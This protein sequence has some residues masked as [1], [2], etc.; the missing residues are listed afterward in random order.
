MKKFPFISVLLLLTINVLFLFLPLT[1][2]FGYE[3]SLFNS[4]LVV[5][6]SG[7]LTIN[8]I[9]HFRKQGRGKTLAELAKW[10]LIFFVIP[11]LISLVNSLFTGFCSFVQGLSFYFIFVFPALIIGSAIGAA[12]IY[13]WTRYKFIIFALLMLLTAFITVYEIYFNPQSYFYNPLFGYFPGTI[14]DEGLSVDLKLLLYRLAN[15]LYFG[16]LFIA[17]FIF[18]FKKISLRKRIFIVSFLIV[19]PAGFVTVSPYLGYSTTV[20]SLTGEL[21][22]KIETEHFTINFDKGTSVEE[23]ELIAQYHEYYYSELKKYFNGGVKQKIESF[24][25]YDRLRKKKLFGAENADVAKPWLRQLYVTKDNINATLRHEIAH[26]F[27]ANFGAS[28]FKVAE[29]FNPSLT[30]GIAMAA[31]P[32][33]GENYIDYTAALA[34]KN[35]YKIDI[36]NLF[37]GLNFFAQN[38]SLSYIYAGSFVKYLVD[39]YGIKKFKQLYTDT[40]FGKIYGKNINLLESE[41]FNYLSSWKADNKNEA[42][43]YFGRKSIFAKVC[44]R[45][46]ADHLTRA[47]QYF[48]DKKYYEAEKMFSNVLKKSESYSALTGLAALF[49]ETGRKDSAIFVLSRGIK[50]FENTAYFFNLQFQLADLFAGKGD[51]IPADSLYKKIA[52]EKPNVTLVNLSVMRIALQDYDTLLT[53]YV[54]G[55]NIDRYLIL[56]ELNERSYNYHSIPS[57]INLSA[58]FEENYRVFLKQ[59]DKTLIVSDEYSAY[60]VY[61]LSEYALKNSDFVRARRLAALAVRYKADKNFLYIANEQFNKSDW[62]YRNILLK[63]NFIKNN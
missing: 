7:V 22:Y 39:N 14:F 51:Y 45:Y 63:S 54:N 52:A 53:T 4:L 1:S 26:C 41:Y 11:L 47:W 13:L 3:F 16:I 5:V 17:A 28:I 27:T 59:F 58:A 25:F 57:I 23:K 33:Y 35:G 34:Y 48:N 42:D 56:R 30:E 50:K 61:S 40:N 6:L 62:L 44:P 46:I 12:S 32:F 2:V 49:K 8:S 55:K 19:I 15:I 37:T 31:D 60:A 24:I 38:S 10:L 21:N 36:K 18:I 9:T 43:Y 29:W 20:G